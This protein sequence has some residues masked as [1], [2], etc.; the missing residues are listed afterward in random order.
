MMII[1][2]RLAHK[3][4]LLLLEFLHSKYP[5]PDV[6]ARFQKELCLTIRFPTKDIYLYGSCRGTEITISVLDREKP[7]NSAEAGGARV[8]TFDAVQHGHGQRQPTVSH[9][10]R[11]RGVD[12]DRYRR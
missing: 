2:K 5:V 6:S 11:K 4:T 9:H 10:V 7:R 3:K 8:L 1:G 12:A